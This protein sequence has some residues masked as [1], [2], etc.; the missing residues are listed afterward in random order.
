MASF[1]CWLTEAW[2]HVGQWL[3][4]GIWPDL[5]GPSLALPVL[6]DYWKS[7]RLNLKG[8]V[9]RFEGLLSF[10]VSFRYLGMT[11]R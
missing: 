9:E 2:G 5:V 1:L 7:Q 4:G 10:L 11:G 6:L 8:L 3:K